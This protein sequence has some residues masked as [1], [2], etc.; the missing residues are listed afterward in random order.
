MPAPALEPAALATS[1]PAPAG[2]P[3]PAPART[4]VPSGK[5]TKATP[6]KRESPETVRWSLEAEAPSAV[7]VADAEPTT[8]ATNGA[9]ASAATPKG[10]ATRASDPTDALQ[11]TVKANAK[12]KRR[13]GLFGR[14]R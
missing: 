5:M 4:R 11:V 3:A 13:F 6:T 12:K 7:D 10:D 14:A 8:A 9:H 2:A 1:A